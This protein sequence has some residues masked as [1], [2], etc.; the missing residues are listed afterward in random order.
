MSP[1]DVHGMCGVVV[2]SSSYFETL[3]LMWSNSFGMKLKMKF[4]AF[5]LVYVLSHFCFP[6]ALIFS[7]KYLK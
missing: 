3:F 6:V 4:W 1:C 5:H 7:Y 2:C